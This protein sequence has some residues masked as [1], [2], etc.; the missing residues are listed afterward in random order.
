M[1]PDQGNWLLNMN[2]MDFMMH[3]AMLWPT[4]SLLKGKKNVVKLAESWEEDD[5][6]LKPLSMGDDDEDGWDRWENWN[7]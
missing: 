5:E 2:I 1:K 6:F 3:N 7:F 4:L